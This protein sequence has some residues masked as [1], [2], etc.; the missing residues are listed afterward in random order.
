MKTELYMEMIN[1]KEEKYMAEKLNDTASE[2]SQGKENISA[3]NNTDKK[4]DK[5]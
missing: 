3:E 4:K 1:D 2:E 5:Q